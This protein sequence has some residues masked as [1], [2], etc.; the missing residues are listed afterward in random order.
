MKYR[1]S[2]WLVL[3]LAPTL[4]P[5]MAHAHVKWFVDDSHAFT[6]AGYFFDSLFAF[7]LAGAFLFVAAASLLQR[8]ARQNVRSYDFLY[9]PV[10]K[11]WMKNPS[12]YIN[13]LLKFSLGILLLANLLQGHFIAPNFVRDGGSFEYALIQALLILLLIVDV[14]L[15][16]LAL[17]VF[18][19][20]LF[21]L[22]PITSAID[23]TPELIALSI[24]LFFTSPRYAEGRFNTNFFGKQYRIQHRALAVGIVQFGLGLQLIIL[25]FHDKLLHPGYGLAFLHEYPVFNFPHY[26]G[27]HSFTNTHFVFGAG[28]AE[29]CFG[30]LLVANIAPRIAS[31][32]IVIIFT[33]TGIVLGPEELLGHVPIIAMALVLLLTPLPGFAAPEA[34]LDSQLLPD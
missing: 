1:L 27:W 8:H 29:L 18:S 4:F 31:L 25:T 34:Q 19:L 17:F 5:V 2:L 26:F 3:C 28:M 32:L 23:Y 22:F 30:V 6:E 16:A 12:R 7:I 10:S 9:A 15:F 11:L 21:L 13:T 24:A 33:L 14:S 20:L